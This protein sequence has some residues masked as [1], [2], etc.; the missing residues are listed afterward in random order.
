ML[1]WILLP[2]SDYP[3]CDGWQTHDVKLIRQPIDLAA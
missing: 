2:E 1:L 3:A